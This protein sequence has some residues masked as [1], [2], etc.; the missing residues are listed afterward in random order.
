[1]VLAHQL[2]YYLPENIFWVLGY[3]AQLGQFYF[4]RDLKWLICNMKTTKYKKLVLAQ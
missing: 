4:A 3:K 2:I 1:M